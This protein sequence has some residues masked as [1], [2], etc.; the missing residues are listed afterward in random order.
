[1]SA[2]RRPRGFSLVELVVVIGI[3]ALLISILMPALTRARDQAVRVQCM[4]NVRQL[5]I[6]CHMYVNENKK[7]WIFSN[8]LPQ[9]AKSPLGWLY[10]YPK[11]SQ[12]EDVEASALFPYLKSRD[13]Y[14]C[15]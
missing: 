12:P 1:M 14:R 6:G 10:R 8:W 5:L 15:P 9:G 2:L 4:N 3:I 7:A 13:P 11:L